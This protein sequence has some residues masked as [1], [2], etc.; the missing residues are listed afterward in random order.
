MFQET[1]ET[2]AAQMSLSRGGAWAQFHRVYNSQITV[3]VRRQLHGE[4]ENVAMS[5]A[6][7][8]ARHPERHVRESA[9]T[10]ELAAWEQA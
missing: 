10:N 9:Y 6:R 4:L 5:A 7:N 1:E 2:L 3:P 8:L